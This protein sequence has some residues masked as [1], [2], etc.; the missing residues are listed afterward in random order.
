MWVT[1]L[2]TI[3]K[4]TCPDRET[5]SSSEKLSICQLRS[6]CSATKLP[7]LSRIVTRV[8]LSS[9]YPALIDLLPLLFYANDGGPVSCDPARRY[10]PSGPVVY[11]LAWLLV[12]TIE[13]LRR[14]IASV[15]VYTNS[16]PPAQP[17]DTVTHVIDLRFSQNC[18][19]RPYLRGKCLT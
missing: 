14:S 15:L 18:E 7:P 3:H 11:P 10:R 6:Q 2:L 13:C 9:S 8:Y 19:V 16:P 12:A 4:C 5:L 1:C 17:S